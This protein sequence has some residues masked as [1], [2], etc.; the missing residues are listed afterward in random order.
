MN[1]LNFSECR[2]QLISGKYPDE[3]M[4]LS[5]LSGLVSMNISKPPGRLE[6]LDVFFHEGSIR[7]L[8]I[9]LG[10]IELCKS[11]LVLDLFL[12]FLFINLGYHSN[13]F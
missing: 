5:S 11:R 10:F 8:T 7:R 6:D 1:R 2:I 4:L 12:V 13:R 3:K 9:S